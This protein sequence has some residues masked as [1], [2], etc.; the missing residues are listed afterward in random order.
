MESD[1]QV[2]QADQSLWDYKH[3]VLSTRHMP[4]WRVMLWVKLI[5]A[6]QQMRPKSIWRL[7]AHPDSAFRDAMGW[8]YRIGSK[9]WP[10]ELW[11]FLFRDCWKSD[12]S[13]LAEFWAGKDENKRAWHQRGTTL[14]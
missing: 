2:I 4:S 1:R 9:V 5:E 7:L 14:A 6:V 12:G 11:H 8:Y 13:S 10:Y 3:Q